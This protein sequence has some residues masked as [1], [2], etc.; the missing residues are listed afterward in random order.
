[1]PFSVL[2]LTIHDERL[3]PLWMS[4]PLL[5]LRLDRAADAHQAHGQLF[6]ELAVTSSR[7]STRPCY[8]SN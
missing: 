8:A 1:L 7:S 4:A 3:S 2:A 5:A 6:M